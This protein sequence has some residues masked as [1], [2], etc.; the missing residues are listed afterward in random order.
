[1][2]VTLSE[3]ELQP[4]YDEAYRKARPDIEIKGFRKGK[5]PLNIIKQR[6]GAAIEYEAEQDII[7]DEFNKIM[8]EDKLPILG[9]PKITDIKKESGGI[10]FKVE[11]EVVPDFELADYKGLNIDEP[12]HAVSDEEIREEINK[13]LTHNGDFEDYE[14][15]ED[16]QFVVGLKMEPADKETREPVEGEKAVDQ[17][18]YLKDHTVLPGLKNIVL[19]SKLND[20]FYYNPNEDEKNAPDTLYKTTVTD[21]QK[22]IPKE[23]TNEF[24]ENYSKGRFK[25]TEEFQEELSFQMQDEWDKKTR[26]AVENQLIDKLVD[27]H[28]F[29]PP[30]GIVHKVMESMVDDLKKRYANTPNPPEISI[31]RMADDLRP[32]AQRNVKWELIR[33]KI[34][35]K[36]GLR[37]EEHDVDE[38]A[39]AEAK[40]LNADKEAVRNI[41]MGNENLVSNLLAKKALD[42]LLDF[43]ITN[44]VEFPEHGHHHHDH[45]HDHGHDHEDIETFDEK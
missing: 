24:V 23:F 17:H 28:D 9:L 37:V 39:E 30:E 11:F 32:I 22:L 8:R 35:E 21:I 40:R 4:H 3:S 10:A 15:V 41:I 2:E 44:E 20:V 12:V 42:F 7:N 26:Q 18:I 6:Y 5:V 43:A 33:N 31:D 13:V 14:E 27:A 16:E 1:M 45:S 19:G 29:D 38:L 25:T 34:I 36:E